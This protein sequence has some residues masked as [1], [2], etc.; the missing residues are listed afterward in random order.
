M[1]RGGSAPTRGSQKAEAALRAFALA[2]P[3][4][5]ED[6]PWG[7]V[8][9]KVRGKAFVF[10]ACG[11]NGLSAS[12]KLPKSHGVALTLRFAQPTE[13]GLGKHGWVTVRFGPKEKPPLPL[14]YEWIDESYRAIAPKKLIAQLSESDGTDA[15]KTERRK[16]TAAKKGDPGKRPKETTSS[17]AP[18]KRKTTARRSTA[19]GAAKRAPS[20]K[21]SS[22]N[23]T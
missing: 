20:K 12:V 23:K 11:E 2:Y 19:R 13:Y 18:G 22:R 10:L 15:P 6:F 7:H 21:R 5:H 1:A 8:A 9:V 4:T 3:E 16:R 17:R 14:L